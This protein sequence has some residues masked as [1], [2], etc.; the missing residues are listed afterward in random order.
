[1]ATTAPASGSAPVNQEQES[2]A[3]V[4]TGWSLLKNFQILKLNFLHVTVIKLNLKL[5]TEIQANFN[6]TN[7]RGRFLTLFYSLP[8]GG[9]NAIPHKKKMLYFVV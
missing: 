4:S 2:E 6:C 3:T 7:Y 8:T 9:S 5:C 1:M